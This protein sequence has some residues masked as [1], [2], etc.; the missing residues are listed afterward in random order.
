MPAET[1]DLLIVGAGTAGIPCAVAAAGRG[2][3]T[4]LVEADAAI[5]GTLRMAAGHL[6]AGG[7]RLQRERG[8]DDDPRAHYDDVMRITGG[9]V[10][11]ALLALATDLAPGTI[12]WLDGLGLD[13]D[14]VCPAILHALETYSVPR[15]YWGLRKGVS[16]LAVLEPLVRDAVAAGTLA[17][18]TRTRLVA[19]ETG[20]RGRVT[21]AVLVGPDGAERRVEASA[22]V[23]TTGGYGADPAVF[24]RLTDGLPLYGGANPFSR[25]DG[26]VAAEA[27][28]AAVRGGRLFVPHVGGIEDPPGGHRVTRTDS[29]ALMPH[30]PPREIWVDRGGRRWTREDHP[31]RREQQRALAR[32]PDLTFWIVG[33]VAA[34]AEGP[35]LLPGWPAERL[36]AAWNAHPAFAIADDLPTLAARACVDP[37]GLIAAVAAY[38]AALATG[39]PDPMGRTHRPGPIASPPFFAVRNRGT[40]ATTCAGLAVDAR[41]RVVGADG[42]PVGGLFAAGEVLGR[43]VLS[44]DAFVGGMSLTPAVAF[45]R[46]IGETWAN[47]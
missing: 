37:D 47:S 6:S 13:W 17:V 39:G 33:E 18:R 1:V 44:G 26:I 9:T 15:T 16:I 12:A 38:N 8:I 34:L 30:R 22:V 14:P 23:L 35:P 28:G 36:A 2:A 40:T 20:T 29:P 31:V 45:G 7:T 32:L 42:R 43:E 19:L 5:G 4:L 10:D 11:P 21:G 3:R 25:G 24:A 41:L 46:R 27:V